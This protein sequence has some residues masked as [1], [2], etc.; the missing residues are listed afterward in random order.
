[1]VVITN[2]C[3]R[4]IPLIP[5]PHDFV[6]GLSSVISGFECCQFIEFINGRLGMGKDLPFI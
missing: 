3:K 2:I 5:L 4:T 1:M 6:P